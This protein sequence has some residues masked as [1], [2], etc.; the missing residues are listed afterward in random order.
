MTHGTTPDQ[1]R[2]CLGDVDFPADK[3][4]LV[5][6]VERAGAPEDVVK[7]IRAIPPVDYGSKDEIVSSVP[8]DPDPSVDEVRGAQRRSV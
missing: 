6:A 4:T 8:V 3:D 5:A 1:V 7:A 2:Q